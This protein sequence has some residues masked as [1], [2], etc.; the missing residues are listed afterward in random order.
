MNGNAL[1]LRKY[2]RT[3]YK[4]AAA[5]AIPIIFQQ[6]IGICLNM[7]DTMMIGKLG[8]NELSGVGAANRVFF[9]LRDRLFWFLQRLFCFARTILRC[10][11]HQKHPADPRHRL[12][13]WRFPLLVG[14]GSQLSACPADHLA[15]C[16]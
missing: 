1:S 15:I 11:R 7:I 5:I 8:V 4:T 6:L 14:H 2:D 10:G 3:F 16:R 12:H 13:I 9:C